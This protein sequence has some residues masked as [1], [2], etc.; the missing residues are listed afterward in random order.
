MKA[1]LNPHPSAPPRAIHE[2]EVTADIRRGP[3]LLT[4]RVTGAAP[5]IPSHA[6]SVRTDGLWKTTCFE[7]FV[8]PR[9]DGA[10]FEF[11]FSP[12]TRWAA[13]RFDGYREGMAELPLAAPLIEPIEDGIRVQVDLGSLPDGSWRIALSAV[14]EEQ[15]GTKSYWA[16]AHP[17]GK[18]DFHHEACFALELPAA[19][20]A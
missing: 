5:V 9:N 7:L 20:Q 6:A 1:E 18:P 13:Y 2:I 3:S 16:L 12:S 19:R 4:Y 11:N 8:R 17:P 10:Y 15:D 14:I